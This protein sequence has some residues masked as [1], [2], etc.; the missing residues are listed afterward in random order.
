MR[1]KLNNYLKTYRKRSGLSQKSLAVL[2]GQANNAGVSRYERGH[3]DPTLQTIVA[4]EL[5]FDQAPR[6][7]IPH[8]YKQTKRE[9]LRRCVALLRNKDLSAHQ[10]ARVQHHW[11]KLLA[12]KI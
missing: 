5:L 4:Y 11:R 1:R 6:D 3:R 2:L 7:L 9:L 12:K 8:V 10:R